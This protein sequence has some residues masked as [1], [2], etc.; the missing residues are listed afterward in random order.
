MKA[1]NK[2]HFNENLKLLARSSIIVFIGLFLSK[3]IAYVYRIAIARYYGPEVYG[4]FALA[5]I[6]FSIAAVLSRLGF[7]E[8]LGRYVPFYRG[9]NQQDNIAYLF[10]KTL[11]LTLIS[12]LFFA[13][14]FYFASDFIASSI[15]GN[16]DLSIYFKIFSFLLPMSSVSVLFTSMLKAYEKIGWFSFITNIFDNLIKIIILAILIFIGVNSKAVP[17]SYTLGGLFTLLLSFIICRSVIPSSFTRILRNDIKVN[18]KD[19]MMRSFYA[20]SWPFIIFGIVGSIFYWVDSIMIGIF[21]SAA[22]VGFYNAAVPIALLLTLTKDIF[23]N[24]F[25]PIVTK[26]YARKKNDIVKQL[27]QQ[28]G[29]WIFIINL[30]VFILFIVFPG[31]FINLLFGKE[32]LVAETALRILAFG[33]LST[34]LFEISRDLISMTGKSKVILI[35]IILAT[36]LNIILNYLLIPAYGING[37]AVATAISLIALNTTFMLQSRKLLGIFPMRRKII[38]IMAV[39][40]IPVILILI[41]RNFI[42]FNLIKTIIAGIVFAIIYIFLLFLTN[43]LDENDKMIFNLVKNKILKQIN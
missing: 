40:I 8:G 6:G 14:V 4:L 34:S 1:S 43:C 19:S 25:F 29:K 42:E 22:E 36:V 39:T 26:E 31:V 7:A 27:S 20:Y 10:R 33:A 41:A 30:P 38:R 32:Y 17:L 3:L 24:L 16:P 12:S 35:D 23:S 28:I 11:I 13:L 37:A 5:L 21:R 15:F 18:K 9:K 2:R